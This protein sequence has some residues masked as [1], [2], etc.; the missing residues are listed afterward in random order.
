MIKIFDSE[1]N[2]VYW[3]TLTL[4][5]S[6]LV[7]GEKITTTTNVP[8]LDSIRDRL[9][10]G[11]TIASYDGKDNVDLAMDVEMLADSQIIYTFERE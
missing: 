8:Y 2:L 4:K 11:S 9:S 5:L 6:Q 10:I 3:D 1:N 7:P